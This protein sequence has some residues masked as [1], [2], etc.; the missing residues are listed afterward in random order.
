MT[1]PLTM[2]D[3]TRFYPLIRRYSNIG[4]GVMVD[5]AFDHILHNLLVIGAFDVSDM[6]FKGGTALRKYYLGPAS[7]FSFDLDFDAAPGTDS[8]VAEQIDQMRV[9]QFEF[10]VDVRRDRYVIHITSEL[11][12]GERATAKMDFSTRGLWLPPEWLPPI[13]NP[14]HDLYRFDPPVVPVANLAENVAEKLARWQRISPIRDL[15]DV[16]YLA[17]HV[18]PEWVAQLWVLKSHRD[19]ME[20]RYRL[21]QGDTAASIE[22]LTAPRRLSDFHFDDLVLPGTTSY[23][24]KERLASKNIRI[25]ETFCRRIA[26][27][28]TPELSEI[29]SDQG[30]LEWKVNQ[31][32]QAIR[33]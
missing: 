6:I 28:M 23:G 11:F 16:A 7:R 33:R 15:W 8:L 2:E 32:I 26:E 21:K 29:A 12:P 27:C 18:D 24:N 4:I 10:V 20:Q 1:R 22:A 9:D 5:I 19:M 30:S 3:I 14:L 13:A 31:W 25:V 17:R